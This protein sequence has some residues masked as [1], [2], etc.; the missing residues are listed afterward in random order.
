M[1]LVDKLR[2]IRWRAAGHFGRPLPEAF[3]RPLR[4]A[5]ALEIGGPS[6]VFTRDGLLPVY[7]AL[8]AVDGVQWAAS[9]AWHSLDRE[10]GY[11][12]ERERRG[13]LHLIDGVDLPELD[14]ES[15]D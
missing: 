4:G 13:E 3:V 5:G 6:V 14:D 10:H 1:G 11:R 12:P 9:T 7:P 8:A 2:V 15:Y